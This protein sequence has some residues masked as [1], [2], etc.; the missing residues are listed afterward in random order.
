MS[1]RWLAWA[2]ACTLI[3]VACDDSGGDTPAPDAAKDAKVKKDRGAFTLPDGPATDSAVDAAVDAD[4][5]GPEPDGPPPD[6]AADAAVD[7]PPPDVAPDMPEPDGAV[8]LGPDVQ[9]DEG[10]PPDEGPEPDLGPPPECEEA[11]DCNDQDLCTLDG[12]RL[13]QCENVPL[14]GDCCSDDGDCDGT[15]CLRR[16]RQ[17]AAPSDPGVIV[18]TEMM[19][20]PDAVADPFGEWVELTNRSFRDVVLN[21][22]V[23]AGTGGEAAVIDSRDGPVV[24]PPGG[25]YLLGSSQ[26]RQRNGDIVV[27][28]RWEF[29]SLNNESDRVSL[30][31][32]NGVLVD[33]VV[34][35]RGWPLEEGR[36]IALSGDRLDRIENDDPANWCLSEVE[37]DNGDFG[38]PRNANPICPIP[39]ADTEVDNCMLTEPVEGSGQSGTTLEFRGQLF[40]EGITDRSPFVDADP[41]L[42]AQVG[43]GP[44]RSEPGPAWRWTD[45]APDPDWSDVNGA[46]NWDQYIAGMQLPGPGDYATAFRFSRDGGETWRYC[47]R[48]GGNFN[49]AGALESLES[50]CQ[51][52]PC[53]RPPPPRCAGAFTAETP[54]QPGECSV[55]EGSAICTYDEI[56]RIDCALDDR[57]CVDGECIVSPEARPNPGDVIITELM[58]DP[59]RALPDDEAEWIEVQNVSRNAVRLDGCYVADS[60]SEARIERLVL[61]PQGVGLFAR[62]G[63]PDLNGGL[64]PDAVF[65]F[66]LNNVGEAISLRCGEVEID[67]VVYDVGDDFPVARGRSIQLDRAARD[68]QANDDGANWCLAER[69]YFGEDTEDV[70][71]GTPGEPNPACGAQDNRIDFCRLQPPAE[72]RAN[73]GSVFTTMA[74][75]LEAGVT[76][77]SEATDLDEDVVA[78]AGFGARGSLPAEADWSWFEGEPNPAWVDLA[79]PGAD[80]YLRTIRVPD[81]GEYDF[82][83]RFSRDGGQTWLYCDAEEGSVNGYSPNSTGQLLSVP[84][85]CQNEPCDAPGDAFCDDVFLQTPFAPGACEV[86][87]DAAECTYLSEPRDCSADGGRCADDACADG[88]DPPAAGEIVI[89]EILYDPH[90]ALAES[91]AEWFEVRNLADD[92]RS[93]DGCSVDDGASS[94]LIVGLVMEAD[95]FALFAR[96][97][98]PEV[99]GGLEPDA[100][101]DFGLANGGD[102]LRLRC[103]DTVIDQVGYDDGEAF[104]DARARSIVLDPES[105]D[106]RANDEGARWCLG[107]DAYYDEGGPNAHY[108]TPRGDN[109][110]CPPP[111]VDFCRL[112]APVN[113]E[114][115]VG[116]ALTALGIVGEP[117]VTDRS[118]RVDAHPNLVG[119]AGYGADDSEPGPE[120]VWFDAFPDGEWDGAARDEPDNDQYVAEV[121]APRRAGVYDLAYRFSFDGGESWTYCDGGAGSSDGYR[122]RD[123]GTLQVTEPSDCEPNPCVEPPRARCEGDVRISFA[124]VGVCTDEGDEVSCAY[125]EVRALCGA[126]ERCDD[127]ACVPLGIPNPRAGDVVFTEIMYAP[128]GRLADADAEWFELHNITDEAL[129]LHGCS[130]D[131]GETTTDIVGLVL[132]PRGYALFGRSADRDAN[133]AIAPAHLFDFEL[134]DA[135]ETLT[136][137]C[138]NLEIDAL[139]WTDF[140]PARR[141]SIQLDPDAFDARENDDGDAW[142]LGERAYYDVDG[143]IDDHLGTPGGPNEVCGAPP[144]VDFCRFQFPLDALIAEGDDLAL[145]GRVVALGITDR[146]PLTDPDE[147]LVANAGYGPPDSD[148]QGVGWRWIDA[149]ANLDYD[150]DAEGEP[151]A[152]EYRADFPAPALGLYALAYR[153]SRDGG[154]TWTYCDADGSEN[155]YDPGESGDLTVVAPQTCDP[156]PCVNPPEDAC[157]GDD[158]ALRHG[159]AGACELIDGE[160]LCDYSPER[161]EC[162]GGEACRQGRCVVVA[163]APDAGEVVFSEVMYDPSL[164]DSGAEWFELYNAGDRTVSLAGCTVGNADGEYA[165]IGGLVLEAGARALFGRSDA[166]Q[167]NGGITP[168]H[169][170][171]FPLDN[172]GDLLGL[173]CRETLV[174]LVHYDDGGAF[175]DAE[176]AAISLDPQRHDAGENNNGSSWCLATEAYADGHLGTPGEAN[177]ACPNPCAPNPCGDPPPAGCDPNGFTRLIYAG[178]GDCDADGAA[179]VCEYTPRREACDGGQVCIDGECV[180]AGDDV[181]APDPCGVAPASVCA[182]ERTRIDGIAPG[183]CDEDNGRPVCEYLERGVDCGANSRCVD[184]ACEAL[185]DPCDPNPCAVPPGSSCSPDA[186]SVVVTVGPG[187]CTVVGDEARCAFEREEIRCGNGEVCF[188]GR[189]VAAGED[190]C[191]PN[192]CQNAPRSSCEGDVLVSRSAPGDCR[193][194]GGAPDCSYDSDREDCAEG[195][196][197][198]ACVDDPCQPNPCDD[199]PDDGCSPDGRAV[200]VYE[201]DGECFGDGACRYVAVPEPCADDEICRGGQ[202]A[203]AGD[204]PCDPNPCDSPPPERCG[205]DGVSRLI[206]AEAGA[207]A[208]AGGVPVCDYDTQRVVCSGG[209]VCIGAM[210]VA[211][212][213]DVCDPNPCA[214]A[215]APACADEVTAVRYQ[216]PGACADADGRPECEYE[217]EQ[218]DCGA[219]QVCRAG[220]CVDVGEDPC[221]PNP[222]DSPPDP[223]CDGAERV[224]AEPVGACE[225][226]DGQPVCEYVERR[227]PCPDGQ[228]CR[229]G[230]C[231]PAGDNVCE[232]NP[233]EGVP[234]P[235]CRPN[236]ATVVHFEGPAQ[237]EE[238]GGDPECIYGE[239]E[240]DCDP[241][242]VCANGRC[243]DGGGDVCDPNPCREPPP[244]RCDGADRL[245]A[246]DR[247]DCLDADGDAVCAYPTER[248]PCADGQVCLGGECVRPDG[249]PCDADPCVDPPPT[250]CTADAGA[251]ILYGEAGDCSEVDG[252]VQCEYDSREEACGDREV[253]LAGRCIAGGNDLCDPNP[254]REPPGP[255]CDGNGRIV[256]QGPG[257]CIEA[258]DRAVCEYEEVREACPDGRVCVEGA[259]VEAG[260][261]VCD[262]N[263]CLG[264]PADRC[265]DDGVTRVTHESPGVCREADGEPECEYLELNVECE[266]GEVCV[267]GRC[268]DGGDDAC[269][270]NPCREAPDAECDGAVRV[271]F[272]APG[273][274]QDIGGQPDCD[275]PS[276][277]EQCPGGQVCR[278]GACEDAGDDFCDPNPCQNPP[279][280]RCNAAGDAVVT[281][282]DAGACRDEDGV[283]QCTYERSEDA[284]RR[285]EVCLAGRCVDADPCDPDPCDSP[286]E[287]SCAPDG[288]SRLEYPRFGDC[289]PVDGRAVC[290]YEP[291]RVACPANA[292]VCI[293][294]ECVAGGVDPCD[295]NPCQ[296][297]GEAVCE[298]GGEA[299]VVQRAPGV[300]EVVDDDADC[301]YERVRQICDEGEACIDGNCEAPPPNPCVPNPCD[302]P[303]VDACDEAGVTVVDYPDIGACEV[304]AGRAECTYDPERARCDDGEVCLDARCQAAEGDPC[305]PNPCQNAPARRCDDL[306]ED[307][308]V[309]SAP[310]ECVPA[311]GEPRCEYAEEVEE[312]GGGENCLEGQCRA[313]D[314]CDPNPCRN[315]PDTRCGDDAVSVVSFVALGTCEPVDGAPECSY[316][317]IVE[318]CGE[319]AVCR[320]AECVEAGDDPCEPNPCVNPPDPFCNDDGDALIGFRQEGACEAD[321]DAPACRYDEVPANCGDQICRNGECVPEPNPCD[322]NPCGDAPAPNCAADGVT[323]VV[324][325]GD[326]NCEDI[327]GRAVCD[328]DEVRQ[329]CPGDE[330][331]FDGDCVA[332]P[333]DPCEDVDCDQAPAARCGQDGRSI[334]Q[335]Q[336]FG[337]C[338]VIGDDG[339]CVHEDELVACGDDEVCIDALCVPAGIDVCDPNPCTNAP[340]PQC[341]VGGAAFITF[342]EP[343]ECADDDGQPRCEYVRQRNACDEGESCEAGRCVAAPDDPCDPDPCDRPPPAEC[344]DDPG[345]RIV[346][347]QNGVCVNNNGQASC[348][349]AG[350]RDE[351]RRGEICQEG[352]CVDDGGDPCD[353]NPC[354]NAPD[355]GCNLD[356]NGIVEFS[357]PGQCE[358]EDDQARCEF[359]GEEELCPFGEFCLAG[360]CVERNVCEPN[361]CAD[362]PNPRCAADARTLITFREP[363]ECAADDDGLPACEY[364]SDEAQCPDGQ[365]CLNGGCID[366]GDDPCD[367]N[368][369]EEPPETVCDA[370]RRGLRTF[371]DEGTCEAVDG[372]PDCSYEAEHVDCDEDDECRDGECAPPDP[373]V[374]NP[375]DD[376]PLAFCG[377]DGELVEPQAPGRCEDLGGNAFCT[378]PEEASDCGEGNVCRGGECI[379]QANDPCDPN[380][381][382][383]PPATQCNANADGVLVFEQE[384]LCIADGDEH[385]CQY[386]QNLQ[387]CGNDE[388]CIDAE[389]EP[390]GDD[391]CDPNPCNSA[392]DP[393]CDGEGNRR[394]FSAP[395]NCEEGDDGRPACTYDSEAEA[396]PD[397]QICNF[398]ECEDAPQDLC[399]PNPCDD[400]PAAT[401]TADARARLVS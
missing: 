92:R 372:Q 5:D 10:L 64:E 199:A 2:I 15:S 44:E 294:G 244:V 241:G 130:V 369:C 385:D 374:P 286:P 299:R 27:D 8:D 341:E 71:Y 315:P 218:I 55:N 256:P 353:P 132:A 173:R 302:A 179:A 287:D 322:P 177:P 190:A 249:D 189:C 384:G 318:A 388:V 119:Q 158:V 395:G 126:D 325:G 188:A 33:E 339:V 343:G 307:V 316:R 306:G 108:G 284:C 143:E 102:T 365:V 380:P 154:D 103:N 397:G 359:D 221:D 111:V 157:D 312:C 301:R 331:C 109:P 39:N 115:E 106:A 6:M 345:A 237:C 252:R 313:P 151:E 191:G 295:P 50:P 131:D 65:A 224:T 120:W 107:R 258:D 349:Y 77:R 169:L 97:A 96:S 261:D 1:V 118:A 223:R 56:D 308:I 400:P 42:R 332:P 194:Q 51:V 281:F 377:F 166:L 58:Y 257:L 277:R 255:R 272:A 366:A 271:S 133:G 393:D 342:V 181:C 99:N 48:D 219:G 376:P 367:P 144:P 207:C 264:A 355:P 16:L 89:T 314:L 161:V 234:G 375:C 228:V 398:G 320:D 399:N 229:V 18:I 117:G 335:F 41:N 248:A 268:V 371:A 270:P 36:A 140:P 202:C 145:F 387:N 127:G 328:F 14:A 254:C 9:P 78:Q 246:A 211:S 148:P 351:C 352:R 305:D 259:C 40:E 21:G 80:E 121:E 230:A 337:Q 74:R 350:Q 110:A 20:D 12:C 112:Q 348:R 185:P 266:V 61:P 323:R 238:V 317:R 172:A 128:E 116:Q 146:S 134:A 389:C 13:G 280:G 123:A 88:A 17:C 282:A 196:A 113:A 363:G 141:R 35:G 298:V 170:F 334:V 85:P 290:D 392:P 347:G 216:G 205:P 163:P 378:Y 183:A 31:D 90:G 285:T 104:P 265:A 213:D 327:G 206:A 171:G 303:P 324:F 340:D 386:F 198:G 242:D 22:W 329:R 81:P 401:C 83:W 184:G 275:Y 174:D 68:G 338:R 394:V 187:A 37:R 330:L 273:R 288:G 26:D 217:R 222:C 160:A 231:V 72:L 354:V 168:D 309:A 150:G 381:C 25:V 311:A 227:T 197:D 7:G 260:A 357:A 70:H 212:G 269:D 283:P 137:R 59:E 3:L 32:A 149:R 214:E 57:V 11:D 235:E 296:N 79:E 114:I 30:F 69:A 84:S 49:A 370:D 201:A 276:E 304:V 105:Y 390:L 139:D 368:P 186:R 178:R 267:G 291:Q 215:P 225:D 274:C 182:D 153:F 47:D 247:G 45:A 193:E 326:G 361:P 344:A 356:G 164:P 24:V 73:A 29:F 321:G 253:C 175:P 180:A 209:D 232:P 147:A 4:R 62:N 87:D 91:T 136:V 396:C 165:E 52:A 239:R 310:G 364:P 346:F 53:F 195:C 60:V 289:R 19:I 278:E 243:V 54:R 226:F 297:P 129:S 94:T 159:E 200:L 382:D 43:Y 319:G 250:G 67:R 292:A 336:R 167:R 63:D 156:N 95:S 379:E 251:R 135:G 76:D 38:T 263:P 391:V 155:G 93:L 28:F 124:R 192:P 373:C 300:C 101:F 383:D 245:V 240:V 333:P 66:G 208:T 162:D 293:D 125:D 46:A 262:P 358:V 236:G 138:G 82:A 233:C 220:I 75:V 142:C 362:P 360:E 86:V 100:V 152:D 34:Y 203:P 122:P 23:L 176:A 210:C 279:E 204:D 98:D